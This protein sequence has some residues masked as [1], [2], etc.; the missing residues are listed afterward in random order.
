VSKSAYI[1]MKNR[2]SPIAICYPAPHEIYLSRKAAIERATELNKR[3]MRCTYDVF[4][5]PLVLEAPA[6]ESG[7][8]GQQ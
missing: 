1:V 8:K 3:A 5:V 6:P 2:S 7:E 4:K